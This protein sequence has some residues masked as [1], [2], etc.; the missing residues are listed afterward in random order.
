[1]QMSVWKLA[2]SNL[3]GRRAC[4]LIGVCGQC[5]TNSKN[6]LGPKQFGAKRS[7]QRFVKALL[8]RSSL[9]HKHEGLQPSLV[10][11]L[12]CCKQPSSKR[13]CFV[14][15]L[16]GMGCLNNQPRVLR[17]SMNHSHTGDRDSES[18][19]DGDRD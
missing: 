12:E 11:L 1:M 8:C 2:Q 13:F 16:G 5:S 9:H 14:L 19:S 4:F 18:L 6:L 15:T 17:Y 7:I 3:A 10:A